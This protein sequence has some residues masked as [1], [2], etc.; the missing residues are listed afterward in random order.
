MSLFFSAENKAINLNSKL[1]TTS[2]FKK[3]ALLISLI[4]LNV[5][6]GM[7]GVLPTIDTWW[8]I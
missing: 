8:S 6:E 3:L 1:K 4:V 7:N 2:N 5:N